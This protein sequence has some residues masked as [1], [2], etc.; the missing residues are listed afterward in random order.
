MK[1]ITVHKINEEHNTNYLFIKIKKRTR[2]KKEKTEQG[3]KKQQQAFPC[4]VVM[5]EARG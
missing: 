1:K 3:R 5:R 4:T 2:E